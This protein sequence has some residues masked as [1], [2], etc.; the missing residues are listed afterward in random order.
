MNDPHVK[1]LHYSITHSEG[2]DYTNAPPQEGKHDAFTVRIEGGQATATMTDHFATPAAARAIVDP[3]LR[4]WELS[5]ALSDWS[6]FKFVFERADISDP[7]P[8]SGILDAQT[9]LY[10]TS[11]MSAGAGVQKAEY[12]RPPAGLAIGPDVEKMFDRYRNYRE[13]RTTLSDAANFCL[14]VV[15]QA[16]G[17]RDGAAKHF[18]IEGKVLSKLGELCATK[19]GAQARKAAGTEREFSEGERAWLEEAM[20]KLIHRAAEV[21]NDATKQYPKITIADLPSLQ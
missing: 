11:G 17:G 4:A 15:K 12:P 21:A 7:S 5:S 13:G 6:G 2:I 8:T 3:Y 20:K 10:L 19:G 9:A 1:S 14:T 16:G 18:Y